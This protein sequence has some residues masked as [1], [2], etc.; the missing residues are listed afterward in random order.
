[1]VVVV[2]GNSVADRFACA[3]QH[4]MRRTV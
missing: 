2:D 1:M 4:A 3:E